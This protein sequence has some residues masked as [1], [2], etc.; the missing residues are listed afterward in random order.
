MLPCLVPFPRLVLRGGVAMCSVFGFCNRAGLQG[1]PWLG[2]AGLLQSVGLARR[3]GRGR[4][5]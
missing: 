5:R 3:L 4:C 1:V 2:S